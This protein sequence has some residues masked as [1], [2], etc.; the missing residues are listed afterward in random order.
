MRLITLNQA[1]LAQ[2]EYLLDLQTAQLPGHRAYPYWVAKYLIPAKEVIVLPEGIYASWM[3]LTEGVMGSQYNLSD[4]FQDLKVKTQNKLPIKLQ[5]FPKKEDLVGKKVLCVLAHSS[6]GLGDLILAIPFLKIFAE[7]L[8]IQLSLSVNSAGMPFFHGQK[9][10]QGLHP[11]ILSFDEYVQYDYYIEPSVDKMDALGWIRNYLLKEVGESIFHE[12]FP[13]PE[14]KVNTENFKSVKL[15][16]NALPKR[17]TDKKICLF[18]W[19]TSSQK[20]NLPIDVWKLVI[21]SLTIMDYQIAVTPSIFQTDGAFQWVI[22]QE[23]VIDA[24]SLIE[25]PA[26]LINLV[27]ACDLTISAD[28]SLIHLA[29][30]L[31]KKALCIFLNSAAELYGKAWLKGNYWPGKLDKLYPSVKAINLP[32]LPVKDLDK[33][34]YQAVRSTAFGEDAEMVELYNNL[35]FTMRNQRMFGDIEEV[36]KRKNI[37]F[38]RLAQAKLKE[39]ESQSV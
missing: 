5:G 15:R 35:F 29:G 25:M 18:N 30:G 19:E 21:K 28:T 9:W 12:R 31:R 6:F 14:L 34:I 17:N 23:N 16:L 38:Q 11:E 37:D 7:S 33:I 3:G 2:D 32:R 4:K 13:C 39:S 36:L 10:L 1:Q 27:A 22:S 24:S 20:R 8:N 26:D